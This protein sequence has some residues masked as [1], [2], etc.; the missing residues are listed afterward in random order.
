MTETEAQLR[1]HQTL[2]KIAQDGI[3]VID[4]QG[5]I[6]EVNDAFCDMLGYTLKEAC[7][8]NIADWNSQYSKEELLGR[9]QSFIG[10]SARFETVHRRKDGKLIDVEI[11][12]TGVDIEGQTYFFASSRD[13]TERKAAEDKVRRLTQIY[14]A[15]SQCNPAIVRCTNEA[16]LF[17]KICRDAVDF[18]GMKMAWIGMLDEA[19]TLVK[20]VASFGAGIEYLEGIGISVDIN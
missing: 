9:L 20:P 4:T 19:R 10:K 17:P 3:H 13:I 2:M 1:R 6:V 8:L 15:L 7:Q 14:A 12:T 11:S 5:N 18:G 16:E